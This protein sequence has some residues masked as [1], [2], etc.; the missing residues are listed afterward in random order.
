VC[1][2]RRRQL[3]ALAPRWLDDN[4]LFRHKDLRELRDFDEED[5]LGWKPQVRPH[6]ISSMA[7]SPAWSRRR[8]GMAHGHHQSTPAARP[9]TF[10]MS[11]RRSASKS[12]ALSASLIERSGS[13]SRVHQYFVALALH[14][15]APA[16]SLRPR[17]LKLTPCSSFEW[18][19]TRESA[20]Q[21]H[22]RQ[23]PELHHC[24]WH[25]GRRAK[26][27]SSRGRCAMSVLSQRK[28]R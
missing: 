12:I 8:T 1:A 5:P 13:Q 20:S 4:A 18:K 19:N 22:P 25:E 3:V 21:I 17:T 7:A 11:R 23:W 6:Y 24:R 28:T 2:H 16:S 10:S 26:S 27:R 14:V 9:Q 15:L